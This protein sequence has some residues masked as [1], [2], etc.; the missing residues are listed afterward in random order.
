MTTRRIPEIIQATNY[1]FDGNIYATLQEAR[2]ARAAAELRLF[3]EQNY[4]DKLNCF[5][6]ADFIIK[7][8]QELYN[9]VWRVVYGE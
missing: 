1:S 3:V 2:R 6:V 7:H 8:A 4:N 5:L 9:L